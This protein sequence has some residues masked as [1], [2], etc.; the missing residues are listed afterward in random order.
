MAYAAASLVAET[1]DDWIQLGERYKRE[2]EQ[3]SR[4]FKER[5]MVGQGEEVAREFLTAAGWL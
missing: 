1:D 2:L 5:T 4:H 3:F